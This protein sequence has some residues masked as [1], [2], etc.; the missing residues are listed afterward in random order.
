MY[1]N[2]LQSY[3]D[4]IETHHRASETIGKILAGIALDGDPNFFHALIRNLSLGL[5]VKYAFLT[6]FSTST[7]WCARTLGRWLGDHFGEN[8][9]YLLQDTPCYKVSLGMTCYFQLAVQKL[10]PL[11]RDIIDLE[12]ESYLGV[13]VKNKTGVVIGHL[14]IMDTVPMKDEAYLH[15]VV[16]FFAKRAGEKLACK[17]QEVTQNETNHCPSF[18]PFFAV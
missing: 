3:S 8:I 12:G 9:E 18:R 16:K 6:E 7:P 4:F 11:D 17:A 13:P 2:R 10:F 1:I 15:L 5:H 14:A